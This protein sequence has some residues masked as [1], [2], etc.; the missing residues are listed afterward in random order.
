MVKK[1]SDNNFSTLYK[2]WAADK[3][4]DIVDNPGDY[5]PLAVKAAQFELDSRQLTKE[6]RANAKAEQDLR[7]KDKANEQQQIKGIE[8]KVKSVGS[9]LVDTFNLIQ[10]DTPT[11][12][13]SIKLISFFIGGLFL[14]QLYKEFDILR[15]TFTNDGGNWGFSMALYF[16]PLIILPATGLLFWFRKKIGW[17][18]AAIYFSYTAAG[19]IPMFIMELDRKP[20]GVPVLDTLFPT[21][22]PTVYIGT[23][24]LFG[25]LTWTLCREKMREVYQA[26]KKTMFIALGIGIGIILLAAISFGL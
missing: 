13:R 22:S 15:F 9:S 26:D 11:T 25:G 7:R 8:N 21:I 16:L 5:Q 4:L 2:T 3:L 24:L 6:Q 14:Y 19:A 18:L 23:L 20:T 1:M 10:K 12:D 17:T